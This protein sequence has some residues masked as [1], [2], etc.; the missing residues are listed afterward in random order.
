M[1]AR[2]S[3][4]EL[5]KGKLTG[6]MFLVDVMVSPSNVI[7]IEIDNHDGLTIDQCAELN[8]FIES[9]LDREAE[10]FELQVSSP[11][12]GHYFKVNEQFRR[13]I[14]HELEIIT[15]GNN[16]YR[17]KLIDAGESGIVLE[18]T[19]KEKQEGERKPRLVTKMVSFDYA[20]IKKARVII[21]F[22]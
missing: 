7:H 14:G 15:S 11:G 21:S 10:D 3:I 13:N 5:V 4:I 20:D 19:T 18:V 22:K 2:E 1:I 6:N 12:V 16:S 9:Q 8:R 17:G